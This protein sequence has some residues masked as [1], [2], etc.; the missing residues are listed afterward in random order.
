MKTYDI[1]LKELD[2][3]E[4]YIKNTMISYNCEIIDLYKKVNFF[5][6]DLK[7]LELK[8]KYLD[9]AIGEYES[10][11][12]ELKNESSKLKSQWNLL[13]DIKYKLELRIKNQ[14]L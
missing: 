13:D 10:A 12:E 11:I 9:N 7:Q 8:R 6:E 5:N 2:Y 1:I 4:N 14:T 3:Q